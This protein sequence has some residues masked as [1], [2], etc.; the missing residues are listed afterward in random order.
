MPKIVVVLMEQDYPFEQQK[1]PSS[2]DQVSVIVRQSI[3][4][5]NS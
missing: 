5:P 2:F 3:P 1:N 4:V